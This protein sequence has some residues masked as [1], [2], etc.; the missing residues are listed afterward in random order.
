MTVRT[1]VLFAAGAVL[2]IGL[3]AGSCSSRRPMTA[4]WC[5]TNADSS[6]MFCEYQTLK[7][8]EATMAGLGGVCGPN[9][10]LGRG[11]GD[12]Q[13]PASRRR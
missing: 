7:Q 10:R 11:P 6:S 2:C 3:A 12:D 9:P 1:P 13:P 8:C 4:P 5:F